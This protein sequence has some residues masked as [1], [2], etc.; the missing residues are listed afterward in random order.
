MRAI[1]ERWDWDVHAG[2]TFGGGKNGYTYRVDGGHS[3]GGRQYDISPMT[4]GSGRFTGY[5][6]N[7]FPGGAAKNRGH[8]GIAEGGDEVVMNTPCFFGPREAAKA[9]QQHYAKMQG[10]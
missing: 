10:A 7:V 4:N 3:R 1:C 8:T 6:L 9:A 5:A 2:G